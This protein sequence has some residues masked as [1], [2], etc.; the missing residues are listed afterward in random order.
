MSGLRPL[1]GAQLLNNCVTNFVFYN[2]V[3]AEMGGAVGALWVDENE[4][5]V[6]AERGDSA[7]VSDALRLGAYCRGAA[8]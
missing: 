7:A 5:V 4:L 2:L 1:P 3:I 6:L 8:W